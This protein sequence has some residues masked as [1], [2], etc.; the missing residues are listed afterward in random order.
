MCPACVANLTLLAAGATSSGGV[1][2]FVLRKIF[3]KKQQ[4]QNA[5]EEK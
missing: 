4:K 1:T 3:Q 5:K 2:A